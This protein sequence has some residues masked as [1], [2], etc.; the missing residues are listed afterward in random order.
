MNGAGI[1]F[2]AP[3]AVRS[4]APAR[5]LVAALRRGAG[6][7]L[8]LWVAAGRNDPPR[9][10]RI[11][12]CSRDI[13]ARNFTL[14]QQ[15]HDLIMRLRTVRTDANALKPFVQV[16]DAFVTH[17]IQHVVVTYDFTRQR[18]YVDGR[19]R[20]DAAMPGGGFGNWDDG[21]YLV[22]GNELTGQRPWLGKLYAVT[23]W[24][25]ALGSGE[26]ERLFSAGAEAREPQRRGALAGYD[27]SGTRAL[28]EPPGI[29]PALEIPRYLIRGS[30]DFLKWPHGPL[31]SNARETSEILA[32]IVLFVPLGVLLFT[33][34]RRR[35]DG[36]LKF[37]A[38]VVAI[39][40]LTTVSFESI[41][42]FLPGRTSS[43]IDAFA[44]TVG[45][46]LGVALQAVVLKIPL[47][48]V[49]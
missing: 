26:I 41:Q 47:K 44:N 34:A 35:F 7:S 29:A 20:F 28:R 24:D 19:R 5:G 48:S 27:F 38:A 17:A 43:L 8:E 4:T 30:D 14:A 36:G 11:V 2:A 3:G 9:H 12:S 37:A 13:F 15:G 32:N 45:A 42:Y 16:R 39:A 22:F 23:L 10:A 18:V 6:F 46:A 21:H 25:R 49:S 40:A 1:E 33:P 31:S